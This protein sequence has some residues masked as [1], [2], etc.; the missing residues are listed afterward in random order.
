MDYSQQSCSRFDNIVDI[1]IPLHSS[2][3]WTGSRTGASDYFCIWIS[4]N[5]PLP[6]MECRNK[7]WEVYVVYFPLKS[8]AYTKKMKVALTAIVWMVGVLGS[9]IL[10]T[11]TVIRCQNSTQSLREQRACALFTFNRQYEE[12]MVG[13]TVPAAIILIMYTLVI[14]ELFRN[15]SSTSAHSI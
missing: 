9:T 6:V 12:I 13:T 15:T 3:I 11:L 1:S 14:K 2:P 4:G 7:Y 8:L 10:T 5:L